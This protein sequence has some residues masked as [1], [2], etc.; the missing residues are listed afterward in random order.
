MISIMFD[1]DG[2]LVDSFAFDEQCF[3][4][5]VKETLGH[6][7]DTRW[8]IYQHVT[9]RGLLMELLANNGRS[10]EI[11]TIEPLVKMRFVQKV[12]RH[13]SEAKVEPTAGAAEF[14][15]EL[16]ERDDVNL[17]I[18]TG[19][20]LESA[21]IKLQSAGI[22]I[23]GIPIATSNDHHIRT[24][25]MRIAQVNSGSGQRVVYFGDAEWDKKAC[26][27]LGFKFILLGNRTD[28]ELQLTDFSDRAKLSELLEIQL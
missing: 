26:A 19:G 12:V 6:D 20:W 25:I 27:E 22:D 4:S 18:A 10:D 7:V 5:A 17:S 28:H 21:A 8:D 24:E 14:I 13:L 1:I 2:T 23:N 15:A 16:K 11:A 9:D 3:N